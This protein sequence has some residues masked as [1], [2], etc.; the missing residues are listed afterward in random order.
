MKLVS[1]FT[2]AGGLDLGFEKAGFKTAWANEYDK[3][4]W[5][6]FEANFPHTTLDKRS[7]T[8][9]PSD[10]I[11]NV[12]GIIGGPPCQSWS[13]AGA[14]RGIEDKR[15][16]LFYEY[17]RVLKDK[18]PLFFLAENVSGILLERH[19]KAFEEI[20]QQFR[21]LNYNVTYK[22]LNAHDYDVPQDR[23][24]VIIVGL[25]KKIGKYFEF[26]KKSQK[27][28]TIKDAI[29]DLRHAK[30]AK[31]YNKTN[32]DNDLYAL[33]H[34]YMNGGFSTIYMSRNRVRSWDEPSF[35]IQAGGRHAPIHPM[36]PKMKFIEQNKRI[37][38]PGKEN[39]YRRLSVR[40]CARIQTFPDN[41]VF[42]YNS[43]GDGYKM[44]GNAV[45]VNFAR[46]IASEIMKY[47][48]EFSRL[49]ITEDE[50]VL[51]TTVQSNYT[52]IPV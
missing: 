14:G 25:H 1:L 52:K 30:P 39:L 47:I 2:G 38:V 4:I 50:Q 20:L 51:K 45:P 15:G 8:D 10:E 32:G 16:Q 21:N 41:F 44:I 13:E 27:K 34:E 3:S 26:P 49:K 11:P 43:I 9:I 28:L 31:E 33:N 17:I 6:T 40:E 5:E 42:K 23:K 46:H 7:I 35:T 12:I 48:E 18:E 24:R 29:W 22:L 19:K 37:F 36:A